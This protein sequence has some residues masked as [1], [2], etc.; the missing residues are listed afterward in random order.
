MKAIPL[1]SQHTVEFTAFLPFSQHSL[2]KKARSMT[3]NM[4][5][6]VNG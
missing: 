6:L 1:G 2:D 5:N 3:R 4:S